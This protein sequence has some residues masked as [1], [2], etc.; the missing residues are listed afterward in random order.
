MDYPYT[1]PISAYSK[2]DANRDINQPEGSYIPLI[3][4]IWTDLL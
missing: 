3:K 2:L 1:S 4:I